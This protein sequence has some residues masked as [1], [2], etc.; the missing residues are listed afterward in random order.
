MSRFLRGYLG[1]LIGSLL[2]LFA[3]PASRPA[4]SLVVTEMGD[5]PV[6]R[7]TKWIPGN[8][9]VLPSPTDPVIAGM[10]MV[11]G[12]GRLRSA[13]HGRSEDVEKLLVVAEWA[14]RTE[15]NNA[16][17]PQAGAAILSALGRRKEAEASWL[18]AS[19]ATNWDDHQTDRLKLVVADLKNHSGAGSSWQVLVAH[20][21]R[22]LGMAQAIERYARSL[23]NE[24]D[25]A[26]HDD[27][28]VRYA[29]LENGKLMRDGSRSWG[30]LNIGADITEMAS[31]PRNI[32]TDP[33]RKSLVLARTSFIDALR[34][35]GLLDDVDNV[36]K[37]FK[38]NDGWIYLIRSVDAKERFKQLALASV[39]TTSVPS[40]LL[41]VALVAALLWLAGGLLLRRPA[42]QTIFRL[43]WAPLLG[44]VS[45]ILIYASLH[46]ALLACAAAT[47]FAFVA[48]DPERHRTRP[49]E[50]L[51]PFFRFMLVMI[52]AVLTGLIGALCVGVCSPGIYLLPLLGVTPD[53]LGG[54][55]ALVALS[56]ITLGLLLLVAPAWAIVRKVS[57]SWV[58]ALGLRDLGKGLFLGA[59]TLSVVCAVAAMYIDDGLNKRGTY[60]L[61]NEPVYYYNQ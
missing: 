18:K 28:A 36:D 56:C 24:H 3:Y 15:P 1:A 39:L 37:A 54:S 6:L 30:I 46:L 41:C 31:Y 12:A 13:E 48:F 57:T 58:L 27:L 51:G 5:G 32:E 55:G 59:A 19:R 22:S 33:T 50:D 7:S 42:L 25:M 16:F 17:W 8:R 9:R 45:G 10:W 40:A 2:V 4:M 52:A 47:M 21:L 34:K 11:E 23:V 38:S 49:S 43:P 61:D 60:I 44:L 20:S 29:T 14:G 26:T 53:Y 35:A